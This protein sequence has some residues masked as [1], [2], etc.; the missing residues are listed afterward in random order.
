MINGAVRKDI[1]CIVG[2]VLDL[3]PDMIHGDSRFVEDLRASSFNIIMLLSEIEG[4]FNME[5]DSDYLRKITTINDLAE[6][7]SQHFKG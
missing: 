7:V 2:N 1:V 4:T 5:F 6:Y 3:E